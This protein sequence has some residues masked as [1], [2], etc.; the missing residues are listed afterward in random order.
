MACWARE[1]GCE[2]GAFEQGVV[3]V[4]EGKGSWRAWHTEDG[5]EMLET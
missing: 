4:W 5:G 2:E 1:R 3:G